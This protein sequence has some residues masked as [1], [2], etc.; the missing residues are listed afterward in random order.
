MR[1]LSEWISLALLV[2]IGIAGITLFP[3]AV[4]FAEA[5]SSRCAMRVVQSLSSPP[6]G[7][8]VVT[9]LLVVSYWSY[10][11]IFSDDAF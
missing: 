7:L 8:I 1:D 3:C 4:T 11:K 2:G 6:I 10:A 5:G 9:V